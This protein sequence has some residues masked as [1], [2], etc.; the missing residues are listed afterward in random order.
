MIDY[1]KAD[2]H[3]LIAPTVDHY[4]AQSFLKILRVVVLLLLLAVLEEIVLEATF[5]LSVQFF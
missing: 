5:E 4:L 1:L 2:A 3:D